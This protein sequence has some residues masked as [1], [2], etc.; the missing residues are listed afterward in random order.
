MKLGKIISL[1]L[2]YKK[3]IMKYT[4]FQSRFMLPLSYPRKKRGW[5][6]PVLAKVSGEKTK[7]RWGRAWRH[8]K[9]RYNPFLYNA[10]VRRYNAGL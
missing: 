6:H 10:Q 7:I 9:K 3:K 1:V 5:R 8:P 4:T 2:L